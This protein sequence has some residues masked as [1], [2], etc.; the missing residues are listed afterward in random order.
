MI[1]K[2]LDVDDSGVND[3]Q[4]QMVNDGQNTPSVLK[5]VR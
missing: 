2:F 5:R 1:G 3:C 4:R